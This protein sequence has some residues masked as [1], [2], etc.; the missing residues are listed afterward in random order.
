ME[1]QSAK[2]RTWE[3]GHWWLMPVIL[4]TWETEIGR[5]TVRGLH[6]KIVQETPFPK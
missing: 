5:I 3:A 2:L 1:M 6:R 4:A